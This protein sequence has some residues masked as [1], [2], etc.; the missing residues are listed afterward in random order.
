MPDRIGAR[1]F[2]LEIGHHLVESVTATLPSYAAFVAPEPWA[3][4]APRLHHQP[5]LV[6]RASSV[7]EDELTTLAEKAV[8]AGAEGLVGLGGG[9]ALDTAKYVAWR[10][11]LPLWQF[12]SIA[13]VDAGF[14]MRAGVRVDG[15]VR[16][17]GEAI[18][19]LVAADLALMSAAP[20]ALNRAGASELLACRTGLADWQ[21][22]QRDP[23]V[24]RLEPSLVEAVQTWL[25]GLDRHADEI[26]R[27]GEGGISFLIATLAEIGTTCDAAGHSLFQEGSEHYFAYC[28]EART[29]LHLVHGELLA[30]GILLMSV[31][32][33]QDV[34]AIAA[35]VDR[36]GVRWRPSDLG[37]DVADLAPV[38]AALPEYCRQ[39]GFPPCAAGDLDA[40]T[41]AL[42][43]RQLATWE[44][45]G[46][47]A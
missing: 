33:D 38:L 5:V 43:L 25:I 15:R 39:E 47:R 40:E 27:A 44:A 1:T 14:T 32:Q 31:A 19:E 2:P 22:A 12:P 30:L 36:V 17:V 4:A 34:A 8:A 26:Q 10:T 6:S 46:L 35:L 37:I 20:A 3:V 9:S 28:L 7:V 21:R 16:Y 45:R 24:P 13:S 41:S 42:V 29:G 23:G 18:P 11:G